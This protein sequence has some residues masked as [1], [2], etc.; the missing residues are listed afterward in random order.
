MNTGR[1]KCV[2]LLMLWA[3]LGLGCTGG[4]NESVITPGA[5]ARS[6]AADGGRWVRAL[7]PRP[8][9][10]GVGW[11]EARGPHGDAATQLALQHLAINVTPAAHVAAF[12]VDHRF[13][14]DGEYLANAINKG[15]IS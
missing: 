4:S 12:E 1:R 9:V 14:N 15:R 2:M 11:L 8:E 10:G 13:H 3:T 6:N 5:P 7:Q